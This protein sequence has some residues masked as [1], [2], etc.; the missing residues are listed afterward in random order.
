MTV[1]SAKNDLHGANSHDV[2]R[3]NIKLVEAAKYAL[4]RRLAPAMQHEIAG[5]FQPL[6]MLTKVLDKRLQAAEPDIDA[7]IKSSNSINQL[8]CEASTVC[9]K[10]MAWLAPD[11]DDKLSV[12]DGIGESIKLL[13]TEF[14]LRGF[15][16]DVSAQ[17]MAIKL[18]AGAFR[19][20]F[21]ICLIALTDLTLGPAHLSI[22]FREYEQGVLVMIRIDSVD[23]EK[24]HPRQAGYRSLDWDDV[25]ILANFEG[26]SLKR[27]SSGA[28][29]IFRR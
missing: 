22:S 24:L 23:G 25:Q 12:S 6:R 2:E 1:K 17:P 14:A 18:A 4:L 7:L 13:G 29:L 26:V 15:T 5:G 8:V 10:L 20:V 21:S 28:D 11:K 3:F 19:Q 9:I 16:I 27:L